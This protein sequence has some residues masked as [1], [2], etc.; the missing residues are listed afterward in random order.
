[1]QRQLRGVGCWEGSDH[2]LF[3]VSSFA[4]ENPVSFLLGKVYNRRVLQYSTIGEVLPMDAPKAR[5]TIVASLGGGILGIYC[6]R[7]TDI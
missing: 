3:S 5:K 2:V 4:N 1:M 7:A 6:R